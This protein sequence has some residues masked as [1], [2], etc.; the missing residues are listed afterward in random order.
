MAETVAAGR[1][2]WT[3]VSA[4]VRERDRVPCGG[5]RRCAATQRASFA[6][7]LE[8][9]VK[10]WRIEPAAQTAE[11]TRRL[12]APVSQASGRPGDLDLRGRVKD[13]T[14]HPHS[15]HGHMIARS[16]RAPI[17]PR[18]CADHAN[19]HERRPRQ[20]LGHTQRRRLV[21]ARMPSPSGRASPMA[22]SAKLITRRR[23]LRHS[24]RTR[25]SMRRT[26][27]TRGAGTSGSMTRCRSSITPS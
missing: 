19:G 4:C 16:R 5:S 1:R 14:T 6:G 7:D 23:F 8:A 11:R 25:L 27:K 18:G 9:Q 20:V 26:T 21:E 13:V 3:G 15:E 22:G 24:A 17:L 2:L 12:P 10:S